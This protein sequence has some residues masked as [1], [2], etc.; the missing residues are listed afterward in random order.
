RIHPARVEA[1]EV[2][3]RPHLGREEV[4]PGLDDVRRARSAGPTRGDH[5]RADP[6]LRVGGGEPGEPEP[7][8][9]PLRVVVVERHL[10]RAALERPTMALGPGDLPLRRRSPA[11]GYQKPGAECRHDR[12]D[13][14]H[15][16]GVAHGSSYPWFAYSLTPRTKLS[17]G[18]NREAGTIGRS[19]GAMPTATVTGAAPAPR[20]PADISRTRG[21][22]L[23]SCS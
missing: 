7:D 16:P 18:P 17:T 13:D 15:L 14:V 2:V 3:A 4:L 9:S 1:D 11:R 12:C 6:V 23:R 21:A 8:R 10:Q 22:L 5:Q 19:L 20:S